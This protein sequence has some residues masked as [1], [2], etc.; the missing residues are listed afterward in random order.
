M[1]S[2][3]GS[4]VLS[5]GTLHEPRPLAVSHV[6]RAPAH[7]PKQRIRLDSPRSVVIN[8]LVGAERAASRWQSTLRP[9]T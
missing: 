5:N 3:P 7:R 9:D 2:E 4:R 6:L 1:R 8:R